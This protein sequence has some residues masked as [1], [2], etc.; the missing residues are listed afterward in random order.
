MLSE[1][2]YTLF[3]RPPGS[4]H[5]HLQRVVTINVLPGVIVEGAAFILVNQDLS[6]HI[7]CV[8]QEKFT[9]SGTPFGDF[10]ILPRLAFFVNVFFLL[11]FFAGFC[12]CDNL[13]T[14]EQISSNLY[15]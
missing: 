13:R 3:P 7:I 9:L 14:P 5:Y 15:Q 6:R 10:M 12:L 2:C 1:L 8:H 4:L 11:L